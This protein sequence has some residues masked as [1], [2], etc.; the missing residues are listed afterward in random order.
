MVAAM[1]CCGD[2]LLRT[3]RWAVAERCSCREDNVEELSN[4][5]CSGFAAMDFGWIPTRIHS[6]LE[7]TPTRSRD[8]HVIPTRNHGH[9]ATLRQNGRR[10]PR[11]YWWSAAAWPWIAWP[12]LRVAPPPTSIRPRR[13]WMT[14]SQDRA[15]SALASLPTLTAVNTAPR[16]HCLSESIP[17]HDGPWSV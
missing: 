8:G 13:V 9:N 16:R 4:R 6:Q 5:E 2:G 11:Q 14:P 1:G 10:G 3:R 12:W 7:V 15:A 17:C